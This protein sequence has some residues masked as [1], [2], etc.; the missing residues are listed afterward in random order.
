MSSNAEKRIL[1]VDDN[2]VIATTLAMALRS[3][4]FHAVAAC[5]GQRALEL[6]NCGAFDLLISD[7]MMPGMTGVELAITATKLGYVPIILMMSGV[8]ATTDLLESAR[9]QGYFFEILAKPM[10][11]TEVIN[12]VHSLLDV[13]ANSRKPEADS[14]PHLTD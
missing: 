11:P 8:S 7:V 4:G 2:E 5:S 1:V 10:H 6:L 13:T 12:Y 9:E 3:A 14:N